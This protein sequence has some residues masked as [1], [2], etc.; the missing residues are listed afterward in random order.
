MEQS[1]QVKFEGESIAGQQIAATWLVTRN[2]KI[3]FWSQVAIEIVS[4]NY[5]H[6]NSN[7]RITE[8]TKI[9]ALEFDTF[10]FFLLF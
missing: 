9:L 4:R 2:T 5:N 1:V 10:F 3:N 8:D 7:V 6:Q